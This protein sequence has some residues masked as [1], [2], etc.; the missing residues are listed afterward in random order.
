M[1]LII[2]MNNAPFLSREKG[3]A[4]ET[5][6]SSHQSFLPSND[7][8]GIVPWLATI[9]SG[10]LVFASVKLCRISRLPLI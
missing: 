6:T 1:V 9:S 8:Y 2:K 4:S 10:T 3:G 7:N 5:Q